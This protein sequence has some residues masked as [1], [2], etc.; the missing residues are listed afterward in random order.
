MALVGRRRRRRATCDVEQQL[1]GDGR[2][3]WPVSGSAEPNMYSLAPGSQADHRGGA[4]GRRPICRRRSDGARLD[5]RQVNR[6]VVDLALVVD[7]AVADE[8]VEPFSKGS[9][10]SM[11]VMLGHWAGASEWFA[12]LLRGSLDAAPDAK[13]GR[14]AR[15]APRTPLE[16]PQ[17]RKE[18]Q[19][20]RPLQRTNVG[21]PVHASS[22]ASSFWKT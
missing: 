16:A 1:R 20:Q 7:A 13:N 2:R 17:H 5:G 22:S 14:G 4:R 6:R 10:I 19:V 12:G 3:P 8:G 21:G 15:A 9:V 11:L 18:Q